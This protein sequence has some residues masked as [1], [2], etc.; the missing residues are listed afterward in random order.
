MYEYVKRIH[1]NS[2]YLYF[3]FAIFHSYFQSNFLP[4][5]LFRY[6]YIYSL[7]KLLNE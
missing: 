6:Y 7:T 3:L 1:N 5:Y 2:Q 4:C